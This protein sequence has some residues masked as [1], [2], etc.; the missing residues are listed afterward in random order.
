MQVIE[1]DR[2]SRTGLF[3]TGFPT[4]EPPPLTSTEFYAQDM[5]MAET[6]DTL[7][8]SITLGNCNPKFIRSSLYAVPQNQDMLKSSQLPLTLAVTPIAALTSHEVR[9][10][11]LWNFQGAWPSLLALL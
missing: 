3:P 11:V 2:S 4:A 1:D 10:V 6:C 7:S 8:R 5:G 9:I